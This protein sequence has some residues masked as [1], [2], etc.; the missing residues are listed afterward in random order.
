MQC[1]GYKLDHDGKPQTNV[2]VPFLEEARYFVESRL[3]QRDVEIVLES[4][5]NTNFV[6]SILYPRGNIAESLL[7]EGF[8]K[9]VEWSMAFMKTGKCGCFLSHFV[10][11]MIQFF[12]CF[13][14][15]QKS[16]SMWQTVLR[17]KG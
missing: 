13:A 6:G 12:F 2:D 10:S 4:V 15:L 5:N 8:A 16:M 9:C 1:P 11:P 17:F 14:F 7:R 3:L